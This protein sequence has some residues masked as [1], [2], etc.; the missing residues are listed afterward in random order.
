MIFID[1]GFISHTLSLTINYDGPSITFSIS[2]FS[3]I[4]VDYRLSNVTLLY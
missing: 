1:N 2:P 4:I 3:S